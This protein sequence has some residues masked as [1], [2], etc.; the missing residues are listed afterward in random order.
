MTKLHRKSSDD[1]PEA[2]AKDAFM[3]SAQSERE[4]Q[5][6]QFD[7]GYDGLRYHRNGYRYDKLEDAV[8]YAS[9]MSSRPGP[10]ETVGTFA[11]GKTLAWP[12]DAEQALM[13][14]LGIRFDH[15]AYRFEDFRYGELSDA[16]NYAKLA[17]RREEETTAAERGSR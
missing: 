17:L 7:I 1:R 13:A 2:C 3:P 12:T 8:A 11:Q 4:R 5:M 14:P 6:A 10:E 15:G 16:V 9:L